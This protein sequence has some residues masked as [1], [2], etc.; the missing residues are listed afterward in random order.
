[1]ATRLEELLIRVK[2]LDK[3]GLGHEDEDKEIAQLQQAREK[4]VV[5]PPATVPV[6][7]PASTDNISFT[8]P[9]DVDG[10]ESG[11]QQFSSPKIPAVYDGVFADIVYPSHKPDQIWFIFK[12]N[13]ERVAE[14]MER[15]VKSVLTITPGGAGAFKL[16]DVLNGLNIPY[17]VN[18]ANEVCGNIPKGYPCKLEFGEVVIQGKTQVR[19]Q[20]VYQ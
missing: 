9:V 13:D 6:S 15:Q 18:D 7:T 3:A 2:A 17:S 16:K 1:M 5:A 19:L 8:I 11:G 14:Q 20:N 12:T 10:F 4:E